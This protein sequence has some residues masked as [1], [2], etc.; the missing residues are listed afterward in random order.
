M[1][2]SSHPIL[3]KIIL[4]ELFGFFEKMRRLRVMEKLLTALET[5]RK[6]L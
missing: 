3:V 5:S 4:L 6:V 2:A 1:T